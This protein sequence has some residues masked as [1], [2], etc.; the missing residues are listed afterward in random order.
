MRVP[1]KQI[2]EKVTSTQKTLS[3]FKIKVYSLQFNISLTMKWLHFLKLT[4]LTK[5][6]E[7]SSQEKEEN[8]KEI[9]SKFLPEERFNPL[10]SQNIQLENIT[11]GQLQNVTEGQFLKIIEGQFQNITEGQ[12][13]NITENH[14]EDPSNETT[15]D[16]FTRLEQTRRERGIPNMKEALKVRKLL[17]S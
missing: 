14:S 8:S 17:Y 12:F 16:N 6:E 13:Q 11:E 15:F 7:I 2:K 5:L 3:L 9:D 1:K 4:T 10:E